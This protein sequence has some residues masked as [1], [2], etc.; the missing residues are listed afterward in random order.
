MKSPYWYVFLIASLAFLNSCEQLPEPTATGKQTFG[1]RV[2]GKLWRPKGRAYPA[3]PKGPV[4]VYN[5]SGTPNESIY[6]EAFLGTESIILYLDVPV[7][8]KGPYV[9]NQPAFFPTRREI[10][11][12]EFASVQEQVSSGQINY[13]TDSY[14]TDSLRTGEIVLTR[15]DRNAGVMSGSFSFMGYDKN[16]GKTVEV[17]DG[18][19]DLNYTP[20]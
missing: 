7:L 20:R 19:F 12:A 2:N 18:R 4:Y 9:L 1:C 16:T 3:G 17:T 15:M 14:L 6:I 13:S 10:S 8:G 5:E 11:Y